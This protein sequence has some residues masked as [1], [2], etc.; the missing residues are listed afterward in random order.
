[1][2]FKKPPG[3]YSPGSHF[4]G[5]V[6]QGSLDAASGHR[7]LPCSAFPLP[8]QAP[9]AQGPPWPRSGF[10]SA[11]PALARPRQAR[12]TAPLPVTRAGPPACLLSPAGSSSSRRRAAVT[13]LRAAGLTG[14][15]AEGPSPEAPGGRAAASRLALSS[16]AAPPG[17]CRLH[18]GKPLP[19]GR[20]PRRRRRPLPPGPAE[21]PPPPCRPARLSHQR[22]PA[23]Q[24]RQAT[25]T[26]GERTEP[27]L[28]GGCGVGPE[29]RSA[30][31]ATSPPSPSPPL[32]PPPIPAAQAGSDA[33]HPRRQSGRGG[34]AQIL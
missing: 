34:S 27:S 33:T 13:L 14:R 15:R 2:P 3:G 25:P 4:A 16:P 21:P 31:S 19:R 7:A 22:P 8:E 28:Q 17:C 23:P 29:C 30:P 1:M 10:C 18:T 32:P 24:R 20:R 5:Q 26:G 9:G 6:L 11:L 12:G